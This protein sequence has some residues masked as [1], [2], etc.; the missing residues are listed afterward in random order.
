MNYKYLPVY[1]VT[2]DAALDAVGRGIGLY[3]KYEN[4]DGNNYLKCIDLDT[5]FTKYRSLYRRETVE[6]IQEDTT[7]PTLPKA[8]LTKLEIFAKSAMQGMLANSRTTAITEIDE[9]VVDR[10]YRVAQLMCNYENKEE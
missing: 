3:T 10:A 7:T 2:P 4:I 6:D 9:I 1:F 5:I 8:E